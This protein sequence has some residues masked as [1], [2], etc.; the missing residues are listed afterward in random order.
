MVSS[1]NITRLVYQPNASQYSNVTFNK[2]WIEPCFSTPRRASNSTRRSFFKPKRHSPR[3]ISCNKNTQDYSQSL[4]VETSVEYDLP[5][6]IYPPKNAEPILMIERKSNASNSTQQEP[7]FGTALQGCSINCFSSG[8]THPTFSARTTKN[9]KPIS[10]LNGECS[11]SVKS[12]KSKSYKSSSSS[13]LSSQAIPSS[14]MVTFTN[15]QQAYNKLS[16]SKKS[17]STVINQELSQQQHIIQQTH[18]I[19]QHFQQYQIPPP[20]YAVATGIFPYSA[21][22]VS[23]RKSSCSGLCSCPMCNKGT[24]P[25]IGA[26]PPELVAPHV[27]SAAHIARSRGS[28]KVRSRR[29]LTTRN[30]TNINMGRPRSNTISHMSNISTTNNPVHNNSSAVITNESILRSQSR[31]Q[32][33]D[34]T[35]SLK[36]ERSSQVSSNNILA[37][38]RRSAYYDVLSEARIGDTAPMFSAPITPAELM[39]EGKQCVESS[40]NAGFSTCSR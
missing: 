2:N 4:H 10:C 40:N 29:H 16:S 28:P 7:S 33:T 1:Q 3:E 24:N 6:H 14:P 21:S 35:K 27:I 13:N 8:G 36:Q 32:E 19:N 20:T 39:D 12:N 17:K 11:H 26:V 37:V 15:K 5:P 38:P 18:Q 31:L 22:S 30:S 25:L 23:S 9:F 34:R